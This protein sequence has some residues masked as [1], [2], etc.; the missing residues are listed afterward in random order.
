MAKKRKSGES[1]PQIIGH[2]GYRS[3]CP[4][5]TML[6]FREALAA[7]AEAIETDLH[8]TKDNVVVLSHVGHMRVGTSP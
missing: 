6:S 3:R 7:G 1:L 4:E 5:N 8:L 2:R